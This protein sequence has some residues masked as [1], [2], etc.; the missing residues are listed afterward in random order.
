M[1]KLN[2]APTLRERLDGQLDPVEAGLQLE[3]RS[4]YENK[5]RSRYLIVIPAYNESESIGFVAQKLPKMVCGIVPEVLVIDD[6]STDDTANLA[7]SY[8]LSCVTSPV[9]RGQGASLRTGYLA[10][11]SNQFSVVAII[12]ADGQWDPA[13]LEAVMTPV[14]NG[15]ADIAQGSRSLGETRVGD[16]VRDLGVVVFA[17]IIS[18]IARTHVTDTSSGIRAMTVEQ[19]KPIRLSQPQYQSSELLIGA[20]LQGARLTEIPVV[21]E[22]RHGGESKKGRNL[23][24]A[25]AYATAVIRTTARELLIRYINLFTTKRLG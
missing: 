5:P 10:A 16:K 20:L 23:R 6:G 21:M 12:D 3:L 18:V 17:K 24:Y 25:L 4:L 22:Q 9:N 8:G 19:L 15:T 7:R 13:D 1:S 14:I 2:F 11:I